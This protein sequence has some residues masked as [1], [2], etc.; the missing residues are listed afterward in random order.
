M[1]TDDWGSM[2]DRSVDGTVYIRLCFGCVI[3]DSASKWLGISIVENDIEAIIVG[4]IATGM[5]LWIHAILGV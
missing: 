4:S 5:I 1:T 3:G 2:V